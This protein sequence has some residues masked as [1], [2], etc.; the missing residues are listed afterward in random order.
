MNKYVLTSQAQVDLA[1]IWLHIAED[2]VQAADRLNDTFYAAFVKLAQIPGMGRLRDELAAQALRVWPVGQ[3]LIIYRP[4][5]DP[6]EI[7]RVVSGYRD[8]P[9]LFIE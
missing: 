9:A 3:Y 6:L 1:D 7:V 5:A 4:E 2:N 8:L